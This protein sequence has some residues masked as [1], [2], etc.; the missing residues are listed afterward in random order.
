V[1][2]KQ[3]IKPYRLDA[4]KS[5]GAGFQSSV[6]DVQN[7]DAIAFQYV[8]SGATS[9]TGNFK[10]QGSIDGSSWHDLTTTI[11]AGATATGALIQM[12]GPVL[13]VTANHLLCV[14]KVRVDYTFTSGSGT[15][16]IWVF[17]K[18]IGA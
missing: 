6:V 2:R 1:S 3:L 14:W 5:F 8:W 18:T 7:I 4:A 12:V 13:T 9:P 17:G 16:T 11:A 10:I 15:C